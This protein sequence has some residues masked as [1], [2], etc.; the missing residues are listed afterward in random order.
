MFQNSELRTHQIH[1]CDGWDELEGVAVD[2]GYPGV[3]EIEL[4]QRRCKVFKLEIS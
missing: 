1:C 4:L 3:D 2:G